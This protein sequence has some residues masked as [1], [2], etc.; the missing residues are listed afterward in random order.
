MSGASTAALENALRT[1]NADLTET[2]EQVTELT[3]QNTALEDTIVEKDAEIARLTA[4][5]TRLGEETERLRHETGLIP[6]IDGDDEDSWDSLTPA[7]QQKFDAAEDAFVDA[8]A[9]A[10][11]EAQDAIF[12][13]L[14]L[15]VKLARKH[16][17]EVADFKVAFDKVIE[18]VS[19]KMAGD[20][21]AQKKRKARRRFRNA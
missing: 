8:V 7:Q 16:K 1:A 17:V 21:S 13:H 4:E 11:E 3:T 15:A 6:L 12:V 10:P 18:M 14:K 9:K 20:K 19:I 2:R 5:V